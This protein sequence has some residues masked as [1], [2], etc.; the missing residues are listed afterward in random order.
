M[1]VFNWD[2]AH[3]CNYKCHYCF[4]T[5]AGWDNINEM[6]GSEKSAEEICKA[7]EIVR[8][9]YGESKIY[10]TGGEP[11]LHVGF[12]DIVSKLTKLHYIHVTTNL[13]LPLEEFIRMNSTLRVEFNSTFH[14][15]CAD[16]VKF[17]DKVL[18]LKKAGFSCGVCYLAHPAQFREMLNYKKYFKSRGIDMAITEFQ[19]EFEGRLYPGAYTEDERAALKS[20]ERWGP[21]IVKNETTG[22]NEISAESAGTVSGA[23]L[24]APEIDKFAC[25]AGADEAVIGLDGTARPCGRLAGPALGNLYDYSIEL[26]SKPFVCREVNCNNRKSN[27]GK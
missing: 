7:W 13:S 9:K 12:E 21:L 19:G 22:G 15:F 4:F 25:G 11:F 8:E 20:I 16:P 6:S 2:F 26:L 23:I 14:P 17:A 3:T 10:I 5:A 27:N 24:R 18:R 1:K